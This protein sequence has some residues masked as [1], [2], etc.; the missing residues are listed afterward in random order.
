MDEEE[1]GSLLPPH[2]F[3]KGGVNLVRNSW[4]PFSEG[5]REKQSYYHILVLNVASGGRVA[6]KS[7]RSRT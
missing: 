3:R 7:R 2:P 4:L 6:Q 5:R 1:G